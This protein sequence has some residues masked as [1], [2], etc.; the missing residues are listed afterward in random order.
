MNYENLRSTKLL[1][2]HCICC[3]RALRDAASVEYGV[4]PVCREKYGFNET[5]DEEARREVNQ[6]IWHAALPDTTAQEKLE[7]ADD[8]ERLGLVGVA[9][10][11]RERFLTSAIRITAE[12]VTFGK[13]D[14]ARECDALIVLT[15]YD[16]EKVGE[17]K[18]ALKA[19]FD[20][21]DL[22]PVYENKKFRGWAVKGS[23]AKQLLWDV[24]LRIYPN[25]AG[26][27]PKGYF[28]VNA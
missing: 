25:T 27:G 3:G 14:W 22:T 7:D 4:G 2:T 9:N 20:W 5:I 15:P 1:A 17:F 10:K 8:I 18:A 6:L 28:K 19:A 16:R 26:F 12:K 24:L 11:I 23:E 13:G 21:R